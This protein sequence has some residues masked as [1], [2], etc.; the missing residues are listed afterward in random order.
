MPRM[1]AITSALCLT[2]AYK[3]PMPMLS[4][5]LHELPLDIYMATRDVLLL[6]G[7]GSCV[8][9]VDDMGVNWSVGVSCCTT[10]HTQEL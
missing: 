7:D 3:C 2:R 5:P 4:L 8:I 6:S 10:S 9:R 1:N